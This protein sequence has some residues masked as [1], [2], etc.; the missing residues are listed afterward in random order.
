MSLRVDIEVGTGCH[1]ALFAA[2]RLVGLYVFV[3]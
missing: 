1:F 2:V 3:L